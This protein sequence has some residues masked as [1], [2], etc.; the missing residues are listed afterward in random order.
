MSGILESHHLSS[1]RKLDTLSGA[2]KTRMERKTEKEFERT[3]QM[4]AAFHYKKQ[5]KNLMKYPIKRKGLYTLIQPL[6]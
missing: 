3:A 6:S 4:L 1:Y 2:A 5:G